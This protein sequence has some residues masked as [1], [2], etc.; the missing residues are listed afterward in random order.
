MSVLPFGIPSK[1]T[2]TML[3]TIEVFAVI[4]AIVYLLLAIRQHLL[5]WPAALISVVLFSIVYYDTRL[6]PQSALQ[7]F[8]FGMG[9]YG[10]L[11][12]RRG[13]AEHEGVRVHRW[14]PTQH[15]VAIAL[16]SIATLA[17][18]RSLAATDARFPYLDTFSTVAA[19]VATF[20]LTKKVIENW[21][22]WFVIDA[23]LVYLF[24]A[25]GLE[26]T[27]VLYVLYL[28][29]VIVG[30]LSWLRSLRP[31]GPPGDDGVCE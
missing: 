15:L 22:Y 1:R 24:W 4:F 28:G 18:G 29:L 11:Q 9:I 12:W 19:I 6:Y 2:S 21:I 7:I 8:Y 17:I 14:N 31:S 10:W 13:G 20:M 27:A 23:V 5:C 16:I 30:F 25:S 26:W 3:Q